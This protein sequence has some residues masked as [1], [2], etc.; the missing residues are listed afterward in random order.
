V[1]G[2]VSVAAK[3]AKP[4]AYSLETESITG[5]VLAVDVP[6]HKVTLEDADGKKV[7]KKIQNLDQLKVGDNID[8]GIT[9]ALAIEVSK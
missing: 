6:K 5:K 7:S 3:G 8:I 4:G 2:V 9:E 1:G